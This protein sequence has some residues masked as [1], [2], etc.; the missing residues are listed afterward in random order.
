VSTPNLTGKRVLL[1]GAE[2]GAGKAVASVLAGAG[3]RLAVVAARNDAETAFAVQRLARRLA[4]EDRPVTAQAIDAANEMA[5][6]VMVR[7]VSK[8]LGGLDAVVSCLEM[9]SA[10]EQAAAGELIERFGR[11]ELERGTGGAFVDMSGARPLEEAA[12]RVVAAIA[13]PPPSG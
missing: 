6:R 10:D 13:G 5:V 9:D 7:R 11:K 8:E 4:S 12:A 3:A 2:T 1:L